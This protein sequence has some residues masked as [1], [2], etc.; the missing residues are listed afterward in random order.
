MPPRTVSLCHLCVLCVSVVVVTLIPITTE[1]Q[2]TQRRHRETAAEVLACGVLVGEDNVA[3][4]AVVQSA[5]LTLLL[6]GMLVAKSRRA[7]F[8]I[9]GKE[10]EHEETIFICAGWSAVTW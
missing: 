5:T 1:T 6:S 2:R 7:G 8:D 3:T 9:F 4:A 10:T